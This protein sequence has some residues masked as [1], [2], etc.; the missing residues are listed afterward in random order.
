LGALTLK[1][2]PHVA[3][4]WDV[5]NLDG[6]DPTDSYGSETQLYINNR[7]ILL[8]EPS[9]ELLSP[10]SWLSDKGRHIFD[11]AY[12]VWEEPVDYHKN[13]IRSSSANIY[14]KIIKK[15]YFLEHFFNSTLTKKFLTIIFGHVG[16]EVLS[17]LNNLTKK[18]P[19]TELKSV[20]GPVNLND[21]ET[22]FQLNSV[23]DNSQL[24]KSD[25]CI[26]IGT[27]S[28]FESFRLNLAL[29]RRILKGGFVCTLLSPL[30]DLT[31]QATFK[32]SNSNSIRA[33]AEG[34]HVFCQ[35]LVQ[36]KNPIIVYN[37]ELLKSNYG[38]SLLE[39]L[40]TLSEHFTNSTEQNKLNMLNSTLSESGSFNL[41][42]VEEFTFKDLIS[43]TIFYF[44]HTHLAS[45]SYV[46]KTTEI[47]L[48]NISLKKRYRK[49]QIIDQNYLHKVN[50]KFS[51][52]SPSYYHAPT[53]TFFETEETFCSAEGVLKRTMKL[54]LTKNI[55]TTWQTLLLI[56][57]YLNKNTKPL[58]YKS[59]HNLTYD[60]KSYL[61]F[62]TFIHLHS[63][64]TQHLT[65]INYYL[66][67]KTSV[68]YITENC[69]FKRASAKLKC[70]KLKLWLEDFFTGGR[71]EYSRNSAVLAS[72]STILRT[73]SKNF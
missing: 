26:L 19:F 65:N 67:T 29:R 10:N 62:K 8:I 71:D 47:N 20:A 63:Y 66:T 17:L 52:N 4:G 3:R 35:N 38:K 5:K 70:Y 25:L 73:E 41:T 39:I 58:N 36:A 23:A 9:F 30:I 27:N 48:L 51:L 18:Y 37:N 54:F 11:G 50:R 34:T 28:R 57:K 59:Y 61:K 42:K 68:V 14:H 69:K 33:L 22:A 1:S 7:Q 64:V 6:V 49:T 45:N 13:F 46:K 40:K 12:K 72:C 32:N 15:C 24:K 31:F 60:I 56:V 55:L 16:L 44:L 21:F 53:R 2:F 43:S